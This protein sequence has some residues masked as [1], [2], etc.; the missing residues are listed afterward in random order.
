MSTPRTALVGI[1]D[2]DASTKPRSLAETGLTLKSTDSTSTNRASPP[3]LAIMNSVVRAALAMVRDREETSERAA[4]SNDQ[5]P[6][7]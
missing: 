3:V 5:K 1:L 7:G 2:D 4:R 6:Q